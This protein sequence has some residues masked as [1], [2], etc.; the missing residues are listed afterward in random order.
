[1][2]T[3]A[4]HRWAHYVKEKLL[5]SVVWRRKGPQRRDRVCS[6][7]TTQRSDCD[8]DHACEVFFNGQLA[9]MVFLGLCIKTHL[10]KLNYNRLLQADLKVF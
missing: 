8:S 4:S 9:G 7:Y 6:E 10:A 3:Q 5:Q 2:L 1:M